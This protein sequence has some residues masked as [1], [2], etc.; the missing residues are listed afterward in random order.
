MIN[1]IM[2]RGIPRIFLSVEVVGGLIKCNNDQN[3]V[4]NQ[5]ESALAPG[6]LMV[7]SLLMHPHKHTQL[8]LCT[9]VSN[10]FAEGLKHVF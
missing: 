8:H 6:A 1:Y 4:L 5:K 10:C 3:S 9:Y 7:V 2:C